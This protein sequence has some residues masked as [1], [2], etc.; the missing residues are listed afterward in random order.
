MIH[1]YIMQLDSSPELSS[2]WPIHGDL[3]F[4]RFLS[5]P[6]LMS[7]LVLWMDFRNGPEM[8]D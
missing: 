5:K 6:K 3:L 8:S 4:A 2:S 7:S 1:E